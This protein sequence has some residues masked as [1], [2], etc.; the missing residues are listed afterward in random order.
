MGEYI[1]RFGFSAWSGLNISCIISLAFQPDLG[2][3]NEL[4]LWLIVKNTTFMYMEYCWIKVNSN[5]TRFYL[6]LFVLKILLE[7]NKHAL[8]IP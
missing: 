1:V 2:K 7:N 4:V 8:C 5:L 6:I 3:V